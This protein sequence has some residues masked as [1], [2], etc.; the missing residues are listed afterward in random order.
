[1]PTYEYQCLKCKKRREA[2]QR[3]TAAP[4]KKCKF[5]G[6]KI[7]RLISANTRFIFKG[8]GFYATDYQ[9]KCQCDPKKPCPKKEPAKKA[10]EK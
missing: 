5:C 2:Q 7:E 8:S 10:H 4:L 1:M 6:G 9:K 3:I